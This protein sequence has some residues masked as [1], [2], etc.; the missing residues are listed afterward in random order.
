MGVTRIAELVDRDKSQVSRT[1]KVLAEHG[2]VD[3]D[4][5]SLAYRL[6]WGVFA[7]AARAGEQR[8][9]DEAP[10]FLRKL[11]AGLEERAHLSVLEGA[12]VLTV[13]SESPPHAVQAAGWVGRTVPVYCTSSGRALLFD[14]GR[15]ELESLLATTEFRRSGPNAPRDVRD[16]Y[17]RIMVDRRRGFA[18][19]DEE[20]EPG[21]VAVAAPV[22]N[23]R[24][25]I[26]A[27]LNVSAPKFRFAR[28]LRS[29]GETVKEVADELSRRLGWS[30]EHGRDRVAAG[31]ARP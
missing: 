10:T 9:L 5:R 15:G 6:S 21:L 8:L 19:V 26:V 4:P 2:L 20:F 31:A 16:L 24:G 22:R 7:L 11:V 1:L 13:M 29:S 28:R 14:H 23:F 12:T 18:I 25:D 30:G 17:D 3:R 27:A